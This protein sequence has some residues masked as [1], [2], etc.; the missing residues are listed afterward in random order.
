MRGLRDLLRKVF[1][2]FLSDVGGVGGI[3]STLQEFKVSEAAIASIK[4]FL[5]AQEEALAENKN[6]QDAGDE[7][8]FGVSWSGVY[9]G[10]HQ[11]KADAFLTNTIVE[12]A[13][14]LN[15]MMTAMTDFAQDVRLTVAEE[16]ARDR[17]LLGQLS[18]ASD[19]KDDDQNTPADG[20][21]G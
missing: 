2:V 15:L 16:E 9:L 10:T 18:Q 21:E 12:T 17:L 7:S 19:L 13:A 3:V 4:M 5:E 11:A 8:M 6:K 14:A 20:N 1:T